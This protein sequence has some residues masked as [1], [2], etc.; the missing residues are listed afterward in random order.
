MIAPPNGIGLSPLGRSTAAPI[1]SNRPIL[2]PVTA[3]KPGSTKVSI[4]AAYVMMPAISAPTVARPKNDLTFERQNVHVSAVPPIARASSPAVSGACGCLSLSA[5]MRSRAAAGK[6]SR[7]DR[8]IVLRSGPSTRSLAS[9]PTAAATT[10]AR[11]WPTNGT[12]AVRTGMPLSAQTMPG[13]SHGIAVSANES[14]RAGAKAPSTPIA[15]A[16]ITARVRRR[17]RNVARGLASGVRNQRSVARNQVLARRE[18][19]VPAPR[20]LCWRMAASSHFRA[21]S[22]SFDRLRKSSPER[23]NSKAIACR[24]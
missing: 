10:G 6:V 3:W 12:A 16:L 23:P 11:N 4:E 18:P 24:K 22:F 9:A 2:W 1:F 13:P 19:S 15:I 21:R 14:G 17:T 7:V 5:A 8:I 20:K